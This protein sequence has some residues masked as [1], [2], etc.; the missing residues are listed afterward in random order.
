MKRRELIAFAG[1]ALL[2]WPL[3]ARAATESRAPRISG[4]RHPRRFGAPG[5]GASGGLARSRLCRGQEPR[6][7]V[8]MVGHGRADA[9][10]GSR[11]GPHE[12]RYHLRDLFD[13]VR[14]G[15]TGNQHDPHR[16]RD[17]CRPRGLGHVS[18]LA[19]PGGNITGLA[20]MQSDITAKRL[21]ILKETVPQAT[22]LRR[23]L[24]P[25]R[26]LIPALSASRRGCQRETRRPASDRRCE[27]RRGFRGAFAT[28]A[29]DRVGAVL[30]H[31]STLTGRITPAFWPSSH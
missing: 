28:M 12:G 23:A 9:R 6:H 21:E 26:P 29:H 5:G 11:A 10:S 31:A 15:P 19:R 16:L 24:E 30:V 2:V 1:T 8:P 18:S 27:H 3:V 7:R 25:H 14:V 13:R 22:P 17:A 20:V 4:F